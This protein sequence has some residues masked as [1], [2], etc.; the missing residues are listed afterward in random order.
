MDGCGTCC[1]TAPRPWPRSRPTRPPTRPLASGRTTPLGTAR[2][3]VSPARCSP[4]RR[5]S[6]PGADSSPGGPSSSPSPGRARKPQPTPGGLS[7]SR[8][9]LAEPDEPERG[10]GPREGR[11]PAASGAGALTE[12]PEQG[13]CGKD[14]QQLTGLDAEVEGHQPR[15]ERCPGQLE[16]AQ[17]AGEAEPVDQAEDEGEAPSASDGL[18]NTTARV[19]AAS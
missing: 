4:T 3:P 13:N 14:Q 12:R 9:S 1:T 19:S 5:S 10:D 8:D 18:I 2:R 6:A 15:G 17:R 7:N 16:L 11:R